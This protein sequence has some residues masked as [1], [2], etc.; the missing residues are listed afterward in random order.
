MPPD[1]ELSGSAETRKEEEIGH[2]DPSPGNRS[3]RQS[4]AHTESFGSGIRVVALPSSRKF[5]ELQPP[6]SSAPLS[7][8]P[9]ESGGHDERP[10]VPRRNIKNANS[11]NLRLPQDD[12]LP[13]AVPTPPSRIL[14]TSS[15]LNLAFV[16]PLIRRGEAKAADTPNQL[17]V[18]ILLPKPKGGPLEIKSRSTPNTLF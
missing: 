6:N 9:R 1:Q 10:K 18:G 16:S 17:I 15:P 5:R 7:T 3:W 2:T 4:C 8:N 12:Q 11:E 13:V 14:R